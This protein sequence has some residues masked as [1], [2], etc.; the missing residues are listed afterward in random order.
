[1]GVAERVSDL[2]HPAIRLEMVVHDDASLQIRGDVAALLARAIEGESQARGGVQPMQLAGDPIAG[3]V[4]AANLG[5]G[6]ALADGLV[7]L[8]QLFRLLFHPTDDAGRTDQRRAEQIAQRLRGAILGDELLDVE[9]DRRR[10]ERS[11]YWVGETTSEGNS[12]FVT[13]RHSAQR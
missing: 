1:M 13:P 7:D 2:V 10:L 4:E 8:A 9:I 5:L 11:P 6:H 12:A 3:F